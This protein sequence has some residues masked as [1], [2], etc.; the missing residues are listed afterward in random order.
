MDGRNEFQWNFF[1]SKMILTSPMPQLSTWLLLPPKGIRR[2]HSFMILFFPMS[3][4]EHEILQCLFDSLPNS[5]YWSFHSHLCF[6]CDQD[7]LPNRALY[8]TSRHDLWIWPAHWILTR[9]YY[10]NRSLW[11]LGPLGKTEFPFFSDL[12]FRIMLKDPLE[13]VCF[14]GCV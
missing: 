14:Q 2:V 13:L 11:S 3:E 6:G 8:Q 12:Y 7:Q 1:L 10:L 4:L 5:Q 9:N